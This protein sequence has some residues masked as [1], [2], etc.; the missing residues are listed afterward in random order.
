MNT[1]LLYLTFIVSALVLTKQYLILRS[2]Y[3]RHRAEVRFRVVKCS[4]IDL[5]FEDVFSNKEIE[6]KDLH[7][8]RSI[9]SQL[10]YDIVQLKTNATHFFSATNFL[11]LSLQGIRHK[12]QFPDEFKDEHERVLAERRKAADA[13]LFAFG[14]LVPWLRFRVFYIFLRLVVRLMILLGR[15]QLIT[16][17]EMLGSSSKLINQL[18]A[19]SAS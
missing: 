1:T 18:K 19:A 14:V 10:S 6:Q 7:A 11:N 12:Q 16:T 5:L 13:M 3:N 17:H 8:L 15:R 9:Y 4:V 2:I